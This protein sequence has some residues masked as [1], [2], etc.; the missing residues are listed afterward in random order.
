MSQY[1]RLSSRSSDT[2]GGIKMTD[3]KDYNK[4]KCG[5]CSELGGD[6][7][8]GCYAPID[9]QKAPVAE[10]ALD[11]GISCPACEP[12]GEHYEITGITTRPGQGIKDITVRQKW[13]NKLIL[14]E[15]VAEQECI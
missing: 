15:K 9:G 14:L 12:L 7:K 3:C 8:V 2:K 11:C 5:D 10:V 6:N 13:N 1:N 4:D